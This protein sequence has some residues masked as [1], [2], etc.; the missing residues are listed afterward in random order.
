MSNSG[1]VV[2]P[3]DL[4]A[5]SRGCL[6]FW[7]NV[8]DHKDLGVWGDPFWLGTTR[9]VIARKFIFPW[10]DNVKDYMTLHR[11][12]TRNSSDQIVNLSARGNYNLPQLH[13]QD[14]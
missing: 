4:A 3:E 7:T 8:I 11:G 6:P 1:F 10:T 5:I 14:I 2:E 12:C 13:V 9:C